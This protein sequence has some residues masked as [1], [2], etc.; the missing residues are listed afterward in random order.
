MLSPLALFNGIDRSKTLAESALPHAPHVSAC[1]TREVRPAV[2][3]GRDTV[4]RSR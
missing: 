3:R 2:A 4:L 1:E